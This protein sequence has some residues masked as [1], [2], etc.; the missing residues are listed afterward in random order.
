MVLVDWESLDARQRIPATGI[1]HKC[2][3]SCLLLAAITPI[4]NPY[5]GYAYNKDGPKVNIL[6]KEWK[7]ECGE[8]CFSR[9]YW[10]N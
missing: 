4:A 1:C 5:S 8:R 6:H 7:C 9:E 10:K 2:G 3:K